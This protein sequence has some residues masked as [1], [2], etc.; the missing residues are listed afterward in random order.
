MTHV[1]GIYRSNFMHIVQQIHKIYTT[2][3]SALVHTHKVLDSVSYISIL[4]P[5][6]EESR[7]AL[8]YASVV[9]A[10]SSAKCFLTIT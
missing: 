4:V 10:F 1:F 8:E 5:L 3:C 6:L 7:V 2:Q 9:L